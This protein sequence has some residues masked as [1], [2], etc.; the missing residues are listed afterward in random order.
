L[1]TPTGL[2]FGPDGNLYVADTVGSAVRRYNGTTGAFIDDFIPGGAMSV[3][4][5]QFPSDLIFDQPGRLLV[6]NLGASFNPNDP[7]NLHGNVMT[8]N[9]MTGAFIEN[10]ATDIL[11]ASQIAT[12]TPIPEPTSLVLMGSA[13]A[14]F[15]WWKRRR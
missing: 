4:L 12:F 9:A 5:N 14:G 6:A 7:P 10:F 13:L 15:A 2:V 3:L 11:G 8:F 1:A